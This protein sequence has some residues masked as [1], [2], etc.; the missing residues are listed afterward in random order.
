[1]VVG[2]M[3]RNVL[4]F[5]AVD[6]R[7]CILRIKTIFHNQSCINVHAATEGK[8]EMEEVTSHQKMKEVYDI[9]LYNNIKVLVGDLNVSI[10]RQED[11]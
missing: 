11:E 9:C 7:I 4:D 5:K 6:N 1:M 2:T 3:N 8:G 10:R